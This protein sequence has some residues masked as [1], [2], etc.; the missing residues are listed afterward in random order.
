[1]INIMARE[2]IVSWTSSFSSLVRESKGKN[3]TS[4]EEESE[5]QNTILAIFLGRR[6]SQ[7]DKNIRTNTETGMMIMPGDTSTTGV[8]GRKLEENILDVQ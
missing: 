6:G 4:T 3:F 2:T 5:E 8:V 1:M 7:C